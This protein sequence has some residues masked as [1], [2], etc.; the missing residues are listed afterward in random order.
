[1]FV[2]LSGP[3]AVGKTSI[4]KRIQEERKG[5]VSFPVSYTTRAP[6][7]GENHQSY[8]FISKEQ[9]QMLI[10]NNELMEW[11]ERGAS[12]LYGTSWAALE[13]VPSD[14]VLLDLDV[15]G[16]FAVR[17]RFPSKTCLVFVAPPPP[18]IQTIER[19]LRLRNDNMSENEIR[20]RLEAAAHELKMSPNFDH[21]VVNDDLEKV[22]QQVLD[23]IDS[24]IVSD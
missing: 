22:V 7:P 24:L 20:W 21:V 1:M 10:S 12:G 16:A 5:K 13:E 3:T 19:R 15:A 2:V 14:L 18:E 6:R 9:F 8:H 11:T 23:I 17:S 4:L